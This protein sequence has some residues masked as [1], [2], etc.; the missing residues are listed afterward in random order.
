MRIE[1]GI[2]KMLASVTV[3]RRPM[4]LDRLADYWSGPVWTNSV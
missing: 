1:D 4:V 3:A 2:I